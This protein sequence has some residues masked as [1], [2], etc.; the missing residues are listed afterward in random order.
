M[1]E[2]DAA[3]FE[4]AGATAIADGFEIVQAFSNQLLLDLD[5][6]EAQER[7]DLMIP[8]IRSNFG[9]LEVEQWPSKTPGHWHRRITLA[10]PDLTV[11]QR[12]ALQAVLGSD[13]SR[14]ALNVKRMLMGI[15]DPNRLFR[16]PN[17]MVMILE[18]DV[19]RHLEP[20]TEL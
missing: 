13:P 20:I 4:E 1:S 2:I 6:I 12:I 8:L 5:S 7:Y 16:P 15:E 18:D 17:V 11:S 9:V 3:A 19:F 10:E 14:E